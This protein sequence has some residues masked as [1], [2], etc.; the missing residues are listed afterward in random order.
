M[1]A[2]T[3]VALLALVGVLLAVG[4]GVAAYVVSRDSVGLPVT[5]L[6]PSPRDLSPT[7]TRRANSQPRSTATTTASGPTTTGKTE[8]HRR[9]RGGG[10]SGHGGGGDD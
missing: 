5:K 1:G 10:S 7:G 8:R 3:R 4:I 6:E 9:G 2:K